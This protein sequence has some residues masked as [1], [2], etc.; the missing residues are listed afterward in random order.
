ML[1]DL[2]LKNE[3]G[4]TLQVN[5]YVSSTIQEIGNILATAIANTFTGNFQI[6]FKPT[7]P[8]VFNDYAATLFED[9]ILQAAAEDNKIL[10]IESKFEIKKIN[11]PCRIFVIPLPGAYKILEFT[12]GGINLND[13]KYSD[14]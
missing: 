11:L 7:P 2:L 1:T 3:P 5:E 13:I 4:T 8:V 14:N 9:L 6:S 12:G 10:L